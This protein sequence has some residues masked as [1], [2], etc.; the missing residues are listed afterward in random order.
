[1]T[2]E[3][4]PPQK[5]TSSRFP[6]GGRAF[7]SLGCPCRWRLQPQGAQRKWKSGGG[8]RRESF[9]GAL[10]AAPFRTTALPSWGWRSLRHLDPLLA[11]LRDLVIVGSGTTRGRHDRARFEKAK[12]EARG[13]V[14]DAQGSKLARYLKKSGE[15]I[16]PDD[17]VTN[18]RVVCHHGSCHSGLWD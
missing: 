10:V 5:R 3:Q 6:L 18:F 13:E 12:L 2:K 9:Q 17:S 16:T 1:M 8:L 7:V 15:G 11:P 14:G 4:Q